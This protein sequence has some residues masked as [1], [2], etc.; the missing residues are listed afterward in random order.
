M[1]GGNAYVHQPDSELMIR[2]TQLNALLPAMQFSLPPWNFSEECNF[3]CRK[4]ARFH[5]E[6]AE[7][8]INIAKESL[9]TGD[10]IIR[11]IWWLDPYDENALNCDDQFLVGE[12]LLAAPVLRPH[13]RFRDIYLPSGTWKNLNSDSCINGGVTLKQFPVPLETLP[14]F[15]LL[16]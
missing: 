15:Q 8:I 1:I 3:I 14:I 2:W 16:D 10:P 13:A 7:M 11:P 6:N 9:K 4:F 12:K 5:E